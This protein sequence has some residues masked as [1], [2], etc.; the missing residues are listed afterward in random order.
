MHAKLA[1]RFVVPELL[2][3][4]TRRAPLLPFFTRR[5]PLVR[6]FTRR[7]PLVRFSLS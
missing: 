4:F 6:F 3:F 2:R 5:A 1:L 7:A